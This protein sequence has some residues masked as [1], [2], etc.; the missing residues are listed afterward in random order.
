MRFLELVVGAGETTRL[1]VPAK[2]GFGGSRCGDPTSVNYA[3]PGR[4]G[5]ILA[6]GH[7]HWSISGTCLQGCAAE[8]WRLKPKGAQGGPN[9]A[10]SQ[11]T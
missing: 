5:V 11:Q 2:P 8:P 3:D 6:L 1:E 10:I 9:L 4:R 7:L